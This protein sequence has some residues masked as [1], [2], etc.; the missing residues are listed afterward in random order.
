MQDKLF[1]KILV[2]TIIVL[3]VGAGV[4]PSVGRNIVDKQQTGTQNFNKPLEEILNPFYM[5]ID[6][7]ENLNL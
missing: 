3:F 1:R 7:Q 4:I 6:R 2:L 5:F